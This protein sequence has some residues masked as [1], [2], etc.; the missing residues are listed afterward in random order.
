MTIE[1][2]SN[3][4]QTLW[5]RGEFQVMI[6]SGSTGTV[7]GFCAGTPADELEIEETAMR[8]G[9]EVTIEKKLLKT[10]RQIWTVNPVGGR[11][12]PD[13]IDW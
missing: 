8:E 1:S 2:H 11:D 3:E 13:V 9:T 7:I 10:G 12:E 5:D 4:T 6:K